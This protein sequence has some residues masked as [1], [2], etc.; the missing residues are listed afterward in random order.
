MKELAIIS[1]IFLGIAL[2]SYFFK[3]RIISNLCV[4]IALILLAIDPLVSNKEKPDP[5]I[6]SKDYE[7]VGQDVG[8]IGKD[9]TI[10][11]WWA[12]IKLPR[13]AKQPCN[14]PP[15]CPGVKSQG[16]VYLYADS[17]N[18][19]FSLQT[20]C[21]SSASNS[22]PLEHTLHQMKINDNQWIVWNDQRN[23]MNSP[24][25]Q[26]SCSSSTAHSKGAACFGDQYG[27]VM[28]VST[29]AFPEPAIPS[30]QTLGCQPQDSTEFAQHF[31]CFRV[32][33]DEMTSWSKAVTNANLCIPAEGQ[34]KNWEFGSL[35][36]KGV[37]P[38]VVK[39]SNRVK[40]IVKGGKGGY[41]CMKKD[42]PVEYFR[43]WDYVS[44]VLK[45]ELLVLSWHGA[46]ATP[47]IS[48]G[49]E[50]TQCLCS[51]DLSPKGLEVVTGL[52]TPDGKVTW[53]GQAGHNHAKIAISVDKTPSLVIFGSMN[54]QGNLSA[55][56]CK[57][58]QME[59]GGDFYVLTNPKLWE[60]LNTIFAQRCKEGICKTCP[61]KKMEF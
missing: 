53:C 51:P 39:F 41:P 16:L 2:I 31:F 55:V 17:K 7:I 49:D 22:T 10:V 15:T 33:K 14:Y 57:S 11:D 29:P 36:E 58:S 18:P 3:K 23:G 44:Q 25:T 26:K 28:N 8:P 46:P 45:E 42:V 38:P 43:P 1:F 12:M 21:I 48:P 34:S 35:D 4:V 60:S 6:K 54:M 52:Q 40:M 30:G 27:F 5:S 32:T 37:N 19:T 9:G 13:S 61:P 47:A 50:K 20:D 24:P 56:N 59:R